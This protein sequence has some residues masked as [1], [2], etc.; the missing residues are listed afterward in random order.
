M[1]EKNV[2]T[3]GIKTESK[4]EAV[5]VLP[6]ED[7]SGKHAMA[8][9]APAPPTDEKEYTVK[10]DPL[11]HGGVLYQPGNKVKMAARYAEMHKDNL[12]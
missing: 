11:E 10:T 2:E 6:G 5:A 3:T 8:N 1:A 4:P 9:A 7:S 12:E